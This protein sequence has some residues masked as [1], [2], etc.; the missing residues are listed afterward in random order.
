MNES[1]MP[2]MIA[3]AINGN[4]TDI[5]V[6]S[7]VGR[8]ARFAIYLPATSEAP[9]GR[10]SPDRGAKAGRGSETVLLLGD[11]VAVRGFIGDV[12]RRRGYRTLV[13]QDGL[14]ALRLAADAAVPIN[15][16]ITAGRDGGAVVEH[17]RQRQP[18]ARVLDVPLGKPLT[19]DALARR[20][21]AALL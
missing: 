13:A 8:G 6:E 12:L 21:R 2:E 15:L 1:N 19:P 7:A 9:G 17:L 20:V 10:T 11:D 18:N 14:D 3:G 4:V 16:V 5:S